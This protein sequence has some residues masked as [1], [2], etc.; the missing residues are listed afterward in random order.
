[1]HIHA[2]YL[3]RTNSP[4]KCMPTRLD[5]QEARLGKITKMK[6]SIKVEVVQVKLSPDWGINYYVNTTALIYFIPFS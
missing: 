4:A 1:M 2:D 5:P 6:V 3:T